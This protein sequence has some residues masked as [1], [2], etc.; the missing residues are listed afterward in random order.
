MPKLP[1]PNG[2]DFSTQVLLWAALLLVGLLGSLCVFWIKRY[3]DKNDKHHEEVNGT[4][5][6]LKKHMGDLTQRISDE[7]TR[8]GHTAL[9]I[10]KAN[11]DFQQSVNKEL[12]EIHKATNG[13]KTDLTESRTQ[14]SLIKKELDGL[15]STVDAHQKSLSM[16]AQVMAKHREEMSE[17]KTTIKELSD[18]RL[19]VG[20]KKVKKE[21]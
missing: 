9:S 20:E 2:L 10:S 18:G 3:I 14:V 8:I 13:I 4:I 21:G 6:G 17:I 1:M 11:V 5:S 12:L 15:V 16:G 19:L 7:A